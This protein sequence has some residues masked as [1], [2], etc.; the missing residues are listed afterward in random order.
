[1]LSCPTMFSRRNPCASTLPPRRPPPRK[2]PPSRFFALYS[3]HSHTT[4][5]RVNTSAKTA[6]GHLTPRTHTPASLHC[7]C[8]HRI[9]P[10]R[11]VRTFQH[12][13]SFQY[14]TH[15]VQKKR[16]EG[17]PPTYDHNNSSALANTS[18]G[19]QLLAWLLHPKAS[20][21]GSLEAA[22]VRCLQLPSFVSLSSRKPIIE[23]TSL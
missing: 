11:T 19:L 22:F 9:S 7:P 5:F 2:I 4:T 3:V 17:G 8:W 20:C 23:R 13:S 14:H 6:G 15:S 12:A 1:M 18:P 16:G 10:F 21:H